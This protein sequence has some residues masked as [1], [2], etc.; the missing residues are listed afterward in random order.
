MATSIRSTLQLPGR[1]GD[2]LVDVTAGRTVEPRPAVILLP[3]FK[4]FKDHGPFPALG[5]RLARAGFTALA[6]SVS[7]SGVDEAGEFTRLDRFARNTISAEL[8][9]LGIVVRTLRAGGAGVPIPSS[10]GILGHSRGGGVA[11]LFASES[12]E[13]SALVTWSAVATFRR[14]TEAEAA[15]WR[16]AGTTT[17]LNSRTGQR[18][19]LSTDLLDDVETN[20]AR[21]DLGAAA[22]RVE[23][24]WLLAHGTGDETVPVEEGRA[25]ARAATGVVE[26]LWLPGALHAYGG[27]HPWSGSTPDLDTLFDRTVRHF[28]RVLP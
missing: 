12:A 17:V 3:G 21:F 25:L 5:E 13:I 28:S 20:A 16:A 18:L 15:T 19:P 26:P 24:P 11:L 23:V 2:I 10:V 27:T 6:V 8:D 9:D 1:L 4:G 7:G 14:W 22:G